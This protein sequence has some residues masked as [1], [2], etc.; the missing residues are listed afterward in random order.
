MGVRLILTDGEG[1]PFP[2]PV[3]EDYASIY[4]YVR[5]VHAFNDRVADCANQSFIQEFRKQL[6]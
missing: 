4:E 1:K 6:R 3:R 2:C 5:A